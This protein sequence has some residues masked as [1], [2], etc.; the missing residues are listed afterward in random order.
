MPTD[1]RFNGMTTHAGLGGLVTMGVREYLPTLG[2]WLSA[3]TI[4]PRPGDPQ[5]FNRLSYVRNSPLGRVDP[6]GHCDGNVGGSD[7]CNDTYKPPIQILQEYAQRMRDA[8]SKGADPVEALASISDHAMILFY[9]VIDDYMWAMTNVILGVDPRQK[10]PSVC[11]AFSGMGCTKSE[12]FVGSLLPH[13]HVPEDGA[14]EVG[15]WNPDFFDGTNNQAFHFWYA[16]ASAYYGESVLAFVGSLIHD[17][18]ATV[19]Q[20]AENW[21][22]ENIG[23]AP[24]FIDGAASWEDWNLT[25]AGFTLGNKL[26]PQPICVRCK[27]PPISK[28]TD[29]SQ[30]IRDNLKKK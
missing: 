14:S 5:A 8:V 6:S 24:P 21:I 11:G 2:R 27:D 9:G 12:Y 19:I 1:R 16:V 23:P 26:N 10:S 7:S 22:A 15:D 18:P 4:V 20:D 25:V 13:N 17:P 3:D 28:V 30:W 29:P